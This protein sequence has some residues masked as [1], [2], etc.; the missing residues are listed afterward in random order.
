[1]R[2]TVNISAIFLAERLLLYYK[3]EIKLSLARS[4]VARTSPDCSLTRLDHV[5]Q[6]I[7]CCIR[8]LVFNPNVFEGLESVPLRKFQKNGFLKAQFLCLLESF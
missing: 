5:S 6:I 3:H 2:L 7:P 1:M 8:F 4:E